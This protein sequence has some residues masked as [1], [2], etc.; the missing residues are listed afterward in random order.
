MADGGEVS[1]PILG[2]IEFFVDFSWVEGHAIDV[3][4]PYN[5]SLGYYAVVQS[6]DNNGEL[7]DAINHKTTLVRAGGYCFT[8]WV[9]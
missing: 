1:V 5:I 9:I 8:P 4:D 7:V 2:Q 6:L 3:H